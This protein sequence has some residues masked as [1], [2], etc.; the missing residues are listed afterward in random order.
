LELSDEEFE[1][2]DESG[3][4]RLPT[5]R[6]VPVESKRERPLIVPTGMTAE[7]VRVYTQNTIRRLKER[8]K[9]SS[10]KEQRI[11]DELVSRRRA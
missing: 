8:S 5:R 10:Y 1:K 6:S 3:K 11:Y 7:A 9:L 4:L 2:L